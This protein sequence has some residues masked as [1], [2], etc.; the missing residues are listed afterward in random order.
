MAGA[1]GASLPSHDLFLS[2]DHAVFADGHLVPVRYLINGASIVQEA[3]ESVT[4]WHVELDGHDVLLAEG[5]ACE[6]YLDTGNR[7]AFGNAPDVVALTPDFAAAQTARAVW[8]AGGCA[9]ILTDP[10]EATLRALHLR[11]LARITKQRSA[12]AARHRRTG[13]VAGF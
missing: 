9:P 13:G 2:P 8:A 7:A 10:A 4:Y 6:S 5:L 11:L 3:C 12:A 1:F